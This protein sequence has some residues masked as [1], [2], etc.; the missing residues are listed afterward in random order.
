MRILIK[1]ASVMDKRSGFNGERKDILIEDGVLKDIVNG[2]CIK[3]KADIS[4]D[5]S[6][7]MVIP[8]VIDLHTHCFPWHTNL[9]VDKN[10]L[11]QMEMIGVIVDAGSSGCDDFETFKEEFIEKK[12][13][14]VFEFIN[15]SKL[16]LTKDKLELSDE[17]YFDE[18]KLSEVIK[19]YPDIIKGVKLRASQSVVGELG[20]EPIRRGVSFAH[21]MGLPVMIHIGNMPP[22]IDEVLALVSEGDIITHTFHGKEGGILD[23]DR[24]IKKIVL[25]AAER[26]VRFDVGHGSASFDMEVAK[27]A[28]AQGFIPYSISSDLHKRNYGTKI[29]NFEY[30]IDKLYHCGL[31]AGQLI[32]C[33]SIHPSEI[34]GLDNR[35]CAG[36]TARLNIISIDDGSFRIKGLISKNVVQIGGKDE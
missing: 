15:Y 9:G 35:I 29:A 21:R 19:S 10:Y 17:S 34:V 23:K 12:G 13:T 25:E 7:D 14:E 18:D 31:E 32:D 28:I 11:G 3:E 5:C 2:G 22:A 4:I 16:G 26:G 20:I 6:K 1:N 30:V 36:N 8:E 24:R 27:T 33:I